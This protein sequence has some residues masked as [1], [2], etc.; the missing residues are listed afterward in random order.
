[1]RIGGAALVGS[2]S[3]QRHFF[4]NSLAD[5]T[6]LLCLQ[7]SC[8][9]FAVTLRRQNEIN[10]INKWKNYI[11]IM[12]MELITMITMSQEFI[13]MT[14]ATAIAMATVMTIITI[15]I[16][17]ARAISASCCCASLWRQYLLSRS[18]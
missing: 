11:T 1:M 18:P 5:L 3:F 2:T 15:I 12:I 10:T 16:I 6:K 4:C 7:L 14:V 8:I 17:T 9:S 13:G